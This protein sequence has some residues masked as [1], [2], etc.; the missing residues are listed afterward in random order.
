MK[1]SLLYWIYNPEMIEVEF[2]IIKIR[3]MIEKI[4]N[5]Q[6]SGTFR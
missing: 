4:L 6:Y 5:E 1:P 2:R 3:R